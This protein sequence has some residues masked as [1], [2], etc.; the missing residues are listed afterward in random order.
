MELLQLVVKGDRLGVILVA[1]QIHS[2]EEEQLV[3]QPLQIT[4]LVPDDGQ[5]LSAAVLRLRHTVQQ[6]L[7]VGTDGGQ[8]G[9]QVVGNAGQQLLT[10]AVILLLLFYQLLQLGSGGVEVGADSRKLVLFG[11]GQ[12]AGKIALPQLAQTVGQLP[13]G[14]LD[15]F[16]HTSRKKPVD[17]HQRQRQPDQREPPGKMLGEPHMI[18]KICH[19]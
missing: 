17:D 18:L 13:Q 6:T 12:A 7:G 15:L 14:A 10:V 8:R 11:K 19:G 9:T 3:H 5:I 16:Q 4:G 1:A 2:G